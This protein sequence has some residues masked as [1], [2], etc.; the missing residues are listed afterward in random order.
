MTERSV[1]LIQP[2]C[3]L[4]AAHRWQVRTYPRC[5]GATTR[6]RVYAHTKENV[7]MAYLPLVLARIIVVLVVAL[8]V[9]ASAF[10]WAGMRLAANPMP[11]LGAITPGRAGALWFT[12]RH[13]IGRITQA[14]RVTAFPL[15]RPDQAPLDIAQGP[16]GNLWFTEAH[17]I[18]RM[19]LDGRVR[20]FPLA[21]HDIQP[22][23]ITTGPD[24]NLWFTANTASND[25]NV[26]V[27]ITVTGRVT[28]YGVPT[29]NS[30]VSGITTGPDHNLWFTETNRNKI[31]R[32]TLR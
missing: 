32:I 6:V 8:P 19:T 2:V 25:R 23:F 21:D 31:G 12:E 14:G 27:R 5:N 22:G 10:G 13:G 9:Q 16:D 30:S 29:R 20:L 26:V 28:E 7:D 11:F 18:G 17:A 3:D 4:A 15:P 1:S 24:G